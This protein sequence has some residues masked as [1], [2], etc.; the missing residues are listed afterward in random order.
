MSDPW[1]DLE[2]LTAA[3]RQAHAPTPRR[4]RAIVEAVVARAA[5]EDRRRTRTQWG[6]VVLAVAAA[7][8]VALLLGRLLAA[9]GMRA[10]VRETPSGAPYSA[11]GADGA[12]V[13]P[14]SVGAH[15]VPSIGRGTGDV[16]VSPAP[17]VADDEVR[18]TTTTDWGASPW[19]SAG[20]VPPSPSER[21][22]QARSPTAAA[23]DPSTASGASD[24]R[25]AAPTPGDLES[26]RLLRQAEH[27][28]AHDPAACLRTLA[29]HERRFPGSELA[30]EREALTVIALCGLGRV[31]QGRRRQAQF[32]TAHGDTAYA[33]R[34]RRAC[35]EASK[36]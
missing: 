4:R 18:G 31:E 17:S 3:Y 9:D 22:S 30:L 10:A 7:V 20:L 8:V 32:L 25:P 15:A 34:V 16:A 6:A 1:S 12:A 26:L 33:G 27:Q 11:E 21:R 24:H 35:P 2:S 13:V 23:P 28:L 36:P 29:Q 5:A 14:R 19:A